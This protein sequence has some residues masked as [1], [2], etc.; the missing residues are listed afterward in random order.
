MVCLILL[1]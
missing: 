1:I